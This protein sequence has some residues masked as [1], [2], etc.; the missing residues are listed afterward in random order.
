MQNGDCIKARSDTNKA[1]ADQASLQR[2]L[3]AWPEGYAAR[4]HSLATVAQALS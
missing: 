4:P 2:P 3:I 1:A